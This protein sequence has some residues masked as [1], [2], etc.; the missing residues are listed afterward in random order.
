VARTVYLRGGG[1]GADL[2]VQVDG[3]V[4]LSDQSITVTRHQF[5]RP[6]RSQQDDADVCAVAPPLPLRM[7]QASFSNGLP[8]PLPFSAKNPLQSPALTGAPE[9]GD[10]VGDVEA[11]LADGGDKPRVHRLV[12]SQQVDDLI[13]GPQGPSGHSRCRGTVALADR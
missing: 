5:V 11:E 8:Q 1:P 9:P 2:L 7:D 13:A 3:S 4:A 6:G 12:L 10:E